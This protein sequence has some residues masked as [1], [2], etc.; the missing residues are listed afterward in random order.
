MASFFLAADLEKGCFYFEIL[1]C[2]GKG[3]TEVS[4]CGLGKAET[5][6][7]LVKLVAIVV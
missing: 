5:I 7:A 4:R 6:Y 1:R 3:F 2:K